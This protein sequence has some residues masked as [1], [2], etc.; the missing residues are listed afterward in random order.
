MWLRRIFPSVSRL[1]LRVYYC[2]ETTGHEVPAEGPVLFVANHPNSLLDPAAVCAMARRPVRWL[3]KAPLFSDPV[4]GRILRACG[5]IPVYRR[6]DDPALMHRNEEAFRAA[7]DALAGGSAVGIFPEGTSHSEPALVPL[8]TGAARIALGAARICGRS[9]PISPVGLVLRHKERFRSP[10]LV[11]VGPPVPWEGLSGSGP[12]DETAVRALTTLIEEALRGV[13]VNLERWEDS[14]VVECAEAIYAA[15]FELPRDRAERVR[16]LGRVSEALV[17]L[18]RSQPERLAELYRLVA[19]YANL[20]AELGLAP[21]RVGAPPPPT[22]V[23]GWTLRQLVFLALL[24]PLAVVGLVV[25][26]VPYQVTGLL[27]KRAGVERDVQSTYQ[28]LGGTVVYGAWILFAAGLMGWY[29]GVWVGV[30]TAL[31]LPALAFLTMVVRD[32]WVGMRAN[33]RS[34]LLLRNRQ[35]LRH[36]LLQRRHEL[37]ERLEALRRELDGN[38]PLHGRT[39]V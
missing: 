35:Q 19:R 22:A 39:N 2:F 26:F 25:F 28:L 3:A 36:R 20:L 9:F 13:T 5:A 34:Y 1:A 16:R 8:K 18:R 14:P 29:V 23:L 27:P 11:V 32:R 15:E 21:H 17:R 24:A 33:A 31:L 4:V 6:H 30:G 10:A 7:H 12:E 38:D 37:A